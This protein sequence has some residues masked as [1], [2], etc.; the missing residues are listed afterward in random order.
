MMPSIAQRFR[1][2]LPVVVDVETGGFHCQTD[3]LLEI[4]M[5]TIEMDE[6]GCL[7]A[8]E[9]MTQHLH[10]FDGANI[11]QAALD[12]NGIRLD[13]PFRMAVSEQQG[14]ESLFKLVK[15]AVKRNGC[16]RAVLVGHNA[17]FDL[18]FLNAAVQRCQLD[19]R[20]PF[21]PFTVL[22]TASLAALALGH[23]VLPKA[24]QLAGIEFDGRE[25]HSAL[26]DSEKTAEL[27]CDIHNRWRQ[28]GGWPP[29]HLEYD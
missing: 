18:G 3:A 13:S 11:E 19:K 10:P 12:F 17:H 5:V 23:T 29:P 16:S 24:C 2:F 1:S 27:F 4:A 28:L 7:Y 21:H 9:R 25:A 26:Y 14:L 8:G 6:Q 15:Q 20:N 22:D